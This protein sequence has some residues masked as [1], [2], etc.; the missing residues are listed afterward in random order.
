MGRSPC[1][2]PPQGHA[3][4][5]Q[6][7]GVVARLE[8]DVCVLVSQ[9]IDAMGNQLPLACRAKIVVKGFHRLGGAGRASPVKMPQPFLLFR[10]D[11][12]HGIAGRLVLAP[13]VRDVFE[14]GVA[15]GR[16]TPGLFLPR[17]ALAQF[18][19]SQQ[20]ADRAATRRGAQRQQPSR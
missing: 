15:V 7:A 12:N 6:C 5:T 4:A 9:G 2:L 13:Q 11:R 1:L 19:F 17:R 10:V 20:S 18:E 16:V 14:W 3:V 8:V